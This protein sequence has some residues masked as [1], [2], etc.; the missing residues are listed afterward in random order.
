MNESHEPPENRDGP[1]RGGRAGR[2]G[3]A[4]PIPGRRRPP[5][6]VPPAVPGYEILGELGR[7]GNGRR[8]PGATDP[9]QTAWWR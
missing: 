3:H 5:P 2:A 8:L 7:G 9:T 4:L 6:H 1:A